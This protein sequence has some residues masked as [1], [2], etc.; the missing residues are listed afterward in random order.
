MIELKEVKRP[1]RATGSVIS[2]IIKG[3]DDPKP[4]SENTY[5][6][7]TMLPSHDRSMR[8]VD[9]WWKMAQESLVGRPK[10]IALT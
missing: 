1:S 2:T 8:G 9:W 7:N 10:F 6:A 5:A 4:C 3:R